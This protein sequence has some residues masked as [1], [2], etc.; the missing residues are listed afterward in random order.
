MIS[1]DHYVGRAVTAIN[2][3]TT[4][5]EEGAW[6]LV[7]EGDVRIVNYDEEYELPDV[8]LVGMKLETVIL[9]NEATELHFGTRDQNGELL[10]SSLMRLDPMEYGIDDPGREDIEGVVRPQAGALRDLDV[11]AHPDER[12]SEGP[13]EPAEAT[14][15]AEGGTEQG[16]D[17]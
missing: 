17:E 7:L 8:A 1:L 3:D 10:S 4:P 13:E 11:P 6:E 16:Q 14:A 15:E 12:I 9:S 5:R 2:Y